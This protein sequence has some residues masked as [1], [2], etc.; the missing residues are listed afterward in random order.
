ML[1][2]PILQVSLTDLRSFVEEGGVETLRLEFKTKALA[3]ARH[4]AW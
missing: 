1:L 4:S 3:D 2:K